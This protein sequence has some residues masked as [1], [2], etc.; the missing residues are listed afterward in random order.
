MIRKVTGLLLVFASVVVIWL[1]PAL[2]APRYSRPFDGQDLM[3]YHQV[4]MAKE[5][6]SQLIT[7]WVCVP[8]GITLGIGLSL[9]VSGIRKKRQTEHPP[10]N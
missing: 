8:A 4:E 9:F 6:R 2:V 1:F 3:Q 5:K 7:L 10:A